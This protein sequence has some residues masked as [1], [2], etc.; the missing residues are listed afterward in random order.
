M[1]HM[2]QNALT[3]NAMQCAPNLVTLNLPFPASL[4]TVADSVS[5]DLLLLRRRRSRI[6]FDSC[7]FGLRGG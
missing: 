3:R 2:R 7:G 1:K 6:H 4:T 5:G